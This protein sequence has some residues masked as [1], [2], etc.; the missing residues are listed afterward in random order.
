VLAQPIRIAPVMAGDM[1]KHPDSQSLM[2]RESRGA[3]GTPGFLDDSLAQLRQVRE[4]PLMVLAMNE[5]VG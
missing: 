2:R 4:Q 1:R 5:P 3:P